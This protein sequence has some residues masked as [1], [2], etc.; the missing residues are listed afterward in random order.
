MVLAETDRTRDPVVAA[1]DRGKGRVMWVATSSMWRLALGG[2]SPY[3]YIKFWRQSVKWLVNSPSMKQVRL[4]AGS[5]YNVND[6]AVLKVKVKDDYSRPVNNAAVRL[7]VTMPDGKSEFVEV[8]PSANDGEY[9]ARVELAAFGA[10]KAVAYAS[11]GGR[12]LG[13]DGIQFS[14]NEFSREAE[15]IVPDEQFMKKL[16]EMTGGRYYTL[17]KFAPEDFIVTPRTKQADVLYEINLWHRPVVYLFLIFLLFIE[18]YL[19][20]RSGLQ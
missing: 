7:S 17:D 11:A 3:N 2:E 16:A 1:A 9:E 5:S 12:S 15:E 13:E 4:F 6:T 19:R 10:Y 14:V 8:A 18:W 20:R